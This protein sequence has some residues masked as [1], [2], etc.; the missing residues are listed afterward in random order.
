MPDLNLFAE[1][2]AIHA[3]LACFSFGQNWQVLSRGVC[4]AQNKGRAESL[5]ATFINSRSASWF[6]DIDIDPRDDA[7]SDDK[8]VDYRVAVN[9]GNER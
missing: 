8:R 5:E 1:Y 4:N 6:L 7:R 9:C 2:S 3:K